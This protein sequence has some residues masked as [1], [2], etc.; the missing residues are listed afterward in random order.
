MRLI[1]GGPSCR[2]TA[3]SGGRARCGGDRGGP[4]A[5]T[6]P[7]DTSA[8][9]LPPGAP[10]GA[11]RA[12]TGTRVR[13]VHDQEARDFTLSTDRACLKIE[14]IFYDADD[15]VLRHTITVDYSGLPHA[16]RYVPH[17]RGA[18]VRRE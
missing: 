16:T 17:P 4:E 9:E 11:A 12:I 5:G 18:L 8:A 7:V 6:D 14:Q 2:E 10:A 3:P 1:D 15:D 13:Q